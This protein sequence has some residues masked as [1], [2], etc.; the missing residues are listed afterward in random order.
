MIFSRSRKICFSRFSLRYL[1]IWLILMVIY[2]VS[3]THVLHLRSKLSNVMEY[4]NESSD[5]TKIIYSWKKQRMYLFFGSNYLN[6]KTLLMLSGD[7]QFSSRSGTY[8]GRGDVWLDASIIS[9][10]CG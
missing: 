3:T 1:S 10:I 8:F 9:L 5:D 4:D 2:I 6:A 7:Q